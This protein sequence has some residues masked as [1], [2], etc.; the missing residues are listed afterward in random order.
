MFDLLSGIRVI[1]A[2]VLLNGGGAGMLLSELGADVIKIESTRGGDYARDTMGAVA[3]HYSP[4]AMQMHKEKRSIAV[5]LTKPEGQEI[6]KRLLE[7]ADVFL[8]NFLPDSCVKLGLDFESIKSLKSDI[9]YATCTGFGSTGPYASI[10]THGRIQS[11]MAGAL[12]VEMCDDG[13]VR[14]RYSD[15]IA[16]GTQRS[17]EAPIAGSMF[18]ALAIVSALR[19]RDR[20][21]TSVLI[22]VSGADAVVGAAWMG[23]V[24]NINAHRINS[25]NGLVQGKLQ[26]PNEE[27]EGG[28]TM[29]FYRT[30]DDRFI[31]FACIEQKFFQNF[32]D[33][34]GRPDLAQGHSGAIW[35]FGWDSE[36]LRRALQGIFETRTQREWIELA[37]ERDIA[38]GP[39]HKIEDLVDDPQFQARGIF[40][41]AVHPVAG[42]FTYVSFPALIDGQAY[43]VDLHAPSLGENSDEVLAELGYQDSD[44][45]M[46]MESGIVLAF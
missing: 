21:A 41:T 3:P 26:K 29:Q 25:W 35:D 45:K 28:A 4:L 2:S 39:A 7:S 17:P 10:P 32:L 23:A 40:H 43:K 42:E 22:D 27:S 18:T 36:P 12:P 16:C 6:L 15:D 33:A 34:V 13:L 1:E 38:M 5:D 44:R 30:S 11:G 46:L 24:Y 9:V 31:Y 19:K 14:L 20:D 8:T 37:A